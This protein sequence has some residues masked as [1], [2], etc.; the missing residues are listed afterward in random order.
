MAKMTQAAA[1][2]A[3]HVFSHL[4]VKNKIVRDFSLL[5]FPVFQE[6][7]KTQ[8][9]DSLVPIDSDFPIT[10]EG[11]PLMGQWS[12]RAHTSVCLSPLSLTRFT[13]EGRI[14][15]TVTALRPSNLDLHDACRPYFSVQGLTSTHPLL[16]SPKP[17]VV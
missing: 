6:N 5:I 4:T 11:W 7:I 9:C 1:L 17:P 14:P 2:R 16:S 8:I 3:P 13:L 10:A 12:S 15:P